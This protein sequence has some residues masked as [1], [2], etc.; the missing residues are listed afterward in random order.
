MRKRIVM[1]ALFIAVSVTACLTVAAPASAGPARVASAAS[2]A[3]PARATGT[4][5]G[6]VAHKVTGCGAPIT[7]YSPRQ[8]GTQPSARALGIP[9]GAGSI[10]ALAA[11]WHA[12]WASSMTCGSAPV[13]Q[14][15]LPHA[16]T[17]STS[18]TLNWAG[19]EDTSPSPNYA[20]ASWPVPKVCCSFDGANASVIWVGVG[21]AAKSRTELIQD[22]TAQFISSKNKT[23]YYFWIETFPKIAIKPVTSLAIKPGDHVAVSASYGTL[24]SG[25]ASFVLCDERL[26]KCVSP[27]LKSPGPDNHVEWIAERPTVCRSGHEWLP[28]M[29]DF[30]NP[31]LPITGGRYDINGDGN[32]IYPISHGSP[33]KIYMAGSGVRIATPTKLTDKGQAFEVLQ[34]SPG[35]WYELKN[36]KGKPISC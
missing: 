17:A 28:P 18:S 29:A 33:D 20:Q 23:T 9:G 25:T 30:V 2:S 19:Y 27:S 24:A 15:V 8:P 21:D 6:L 26:K 34:N 4:L 16:A 10:L 1:A 35:N 31:E 3:H 32:P 12:T 5:A 14:T 36:S 13:V 22:G 7:V 11:Q